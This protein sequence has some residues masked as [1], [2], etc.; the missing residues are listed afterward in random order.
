MGSRPVLVVAEDDTQIAG[1]IR[2]RLERLGMEVHLSEN[3]RHALEA[4]RTLIPDAVVLDVMMPEMN[5][6]EVLREI[7]RDEST[8][9]IPALILT[10]RETERDVLKGTE[11]GATDYMSKP[12]SPTELASRVNALLNGKA[13]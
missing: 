7:K 4:I 2:Y 9:H 11:L 13:V 12:F 8:R 6:F 5:G 3:G 10:A 1:L